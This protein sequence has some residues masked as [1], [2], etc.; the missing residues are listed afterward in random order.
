MEHLTN[1]QFLEI[2]KKCC[3]DGKIDDGK[4]DHILSNYFPYNLTFKDLRQYDD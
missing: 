4:L 1:E 2:M 3:K